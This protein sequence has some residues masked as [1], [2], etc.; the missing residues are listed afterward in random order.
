MFLGISGGIT[1]FFWGIRQTHAHTLWRDVRGVDR[2]L[3][4][5]TYDGH[6]QLW[7]CVGRLSRGSLG[8]RSGVQQKEGVMD[9]TSLSLYPVELRQPSVWLWDA[10][11]ILFLHA[12]KWVHCRYVRSYT[13]TSVCKLELIAEE[14]RKTHFSAKNALKLW[15]KDLWSPVK[16]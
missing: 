11:V 5:M 12:F 3:S 1:H 8:W 14:R 6:S 10:S 13:Y 15:N 4:D 7:S 9:C 16:L 2:C